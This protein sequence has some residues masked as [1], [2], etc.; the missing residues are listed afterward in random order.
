MASYPA[1][2]PPS[3]LPATAAPCATGAAASAPGWPTAAT[4]CSATRPGGASPPACAPGSSSLARW[5]R[6]GQPRPP[7]AALAQ[8]PPGLLGRAGAAAVLRAAAL[9]WS[10]LYRF[11]S[12]LPDHAGGALGYLVGPAGV[13]LARLHRLRPARHR[14]GRAGCRHRVPLLLEP[15]RR[16]H[17]RAH[18]RL[19]QA[20]REKREIA[21]DIAFGQRPR[22]SARR[23]CRSSAWRSRSTTRAGASSSRRWSRCRKS[24]RVAK[25]RQKPLFA[26]MPDS[27][28]PQVDLLDGAQ[29]R[30]G[31]RRPP[32]RWR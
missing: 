4:S 9:E 16:A 23:R 5:M 25:E 6:G 2:T 28:L 17:R 22:A 15:R 8:R 19:R 30:A 7:H 32:R 13:K 12:R 27:K 3:P 1:S 21:E 11:E 26:E 24:E 20:R 14:A 29:A 31:D 10:R 18:R